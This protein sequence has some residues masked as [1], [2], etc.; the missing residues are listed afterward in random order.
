MHALIIEDEP[1]IALLIEDYLRRLGYTS[2]DFAVTETEAVA[3]AHRRSPDLITADVRLPQGC[4]IAAVEAIC[5]G[6]PRPVVFITATAWE[7]RA[8]MRDAI[9][10]RKPI[11]PNDLSRAVVAAGTTGQRSGQV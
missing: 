11:M 1:F 6:N 4:G 5:N 8:K 10:V 7:V 9:V 2:F 3:A